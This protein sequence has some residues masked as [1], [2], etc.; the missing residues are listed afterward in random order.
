[1][2]VHGLGFQACSVE[3]SSYGARFKDAADLFILKKIK[4]AL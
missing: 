2:G 4:Q 1:M 3:L